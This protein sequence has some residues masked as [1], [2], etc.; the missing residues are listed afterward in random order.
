MSSHTCYVIT[1]MSHQTTQQHIAAFNAALKSTVEKVADSCEAHNCLNYTNVEPSK[2]NQAANVR[3]MVDY[4][5]KDCK[6]VTVWDPANPT[7]CATD[8]DRKVEGVCGVDKKCHVT[9]ITIQSVIEQYKAAQRFLWDTPAIYHFNTFDKYVA[10][11]CI[12]HVVAPLPP[13]CGMQALSP[14]TPR[15]QP[16]FWPCPSSCI[17][18]AL[19]TLQ[20]PS[21]PSRS[22]QVRLC[23]GEAP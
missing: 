8:R 20:R 19:P 9:D 21:L 1:H 13:V 14:R 6:D 5:S 15:E 22:L 18:W 11:T 7:P 23:L 17:S 2:R 10:S 3:C 12:H 4:A 16:S